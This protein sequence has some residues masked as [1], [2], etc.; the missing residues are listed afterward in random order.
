[1]LIFKNLCPVLALT[2]YEFAPW[3]MFLIALWGIG[4]L[5]HRDS[6][7]EISDNENESDRYE[8]QNDDYAEFDEEDDDYAEDDR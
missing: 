4:R 7:E 3:I 6:A 5:F 1:M 2:L 8:Q